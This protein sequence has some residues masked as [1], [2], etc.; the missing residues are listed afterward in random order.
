MY[1]S[2]GHIYVQVIDDLAGRTLAAASSVGTKHTQGNKKQVAAE[3]GK[4]IGE[5]AKAAGITSV[6]FDRNGFR[7]H[8][9]VVSLAQAARDAGLEF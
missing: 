7:Y 6:C 5:K 2:L 1:K 9:R 8:G 3:V 4:T